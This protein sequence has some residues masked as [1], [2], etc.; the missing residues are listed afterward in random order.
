MTNVKDSDS[1]VEDA[2]KTL[3]RVAYE[4]NH[5]D[6]GTLND[7]LRSF[8]IFCDVC[9]DCAYAAFDCGRHRIAEGQTNC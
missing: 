2:V 5:A 1:V 8:R 9:N 6:A 3:V 4:W 7:A